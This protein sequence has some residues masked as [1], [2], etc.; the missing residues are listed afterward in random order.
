VSTEP[1][2]TTARPPRV[3]FVDVVRLLASL[4]MVNGH[5]IDAVLLPSI[6]QGP[7]FDTYNWARGLVSVCFLMVAGIAFHLSSLARY[8]QHRRNPAAIR[9]RFR[10]ALVVIAGGYFLG[11]PWAATSPDPAQ[12]DLAWRYFFSAGILHC[13]GAAL[14]MLELLVLASRSARQVVVATGVL[15]VLAFALAPAADGTLAGGGWHPLLNWISHGG[16]SPFPLLPWSGNV[17]AGVVVGWIVLPQ[18]GHTPYRI[19]WSRLTALAVVVGALA[20]AAQASPWTLVTATTH[21]S[22]RP[23]FVV[24]NL[25][26]VLVLTLG[27][28]IV[29]APMRSLPRL[30]RILSGET[31][32]I[33][34]FH[35]IVL[36][37]F[38]IQLARRIGETRTLP[39]ALALAAGMIVLTSA[40]T[41]AWH[42]VK[43]RRAAHTG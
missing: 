5:T 9:R 37:G 31:L 34:M 38:N 4:Q 25:A 2:I 16:G 7:I 6:E 15:A 20:M 28:S 29:T 33:Y 27:L 43:A 14:I 24:S 19:I 22:A 17:F 8:E 42:H 41:L 26:A 13:I 18:G 1:Q 30:L 3:W 10:R 35:L 36:F 11:F 12:A 40:Y 21:P 39:E 23:A 32:T